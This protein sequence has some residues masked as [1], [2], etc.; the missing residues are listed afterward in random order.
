[1]TNKDITYWSHEGVNPNGTFK[2]GRRGAVNTKASVLIHNDEI[3]DGL[4]YVVIN[5]GLIGDKVSGFTL[6]GETAQIL[7]NALGAQNEY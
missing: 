5:N 4:E 7:I 3:S 1:M 2:D 6:W